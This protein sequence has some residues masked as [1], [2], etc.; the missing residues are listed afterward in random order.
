[1]KI[2][3]FQNLLIRQLR[4]RS[5]D[6]T[7][8][9]T[10]PL[11]SEYALSFL[12]KYPRNFNCRLP[13]LSFSFNFPCDLLVA[14]VF[15]PIVFPTSLWITPIPLTSSIVL[16]FEEI[17]RTGRGMLYSISILYSFFL[18]MFTCFLYL[19]LFLGMICFSVPTHLRISVPHF[20]SFVKP[21]P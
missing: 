12:I 21:I 11:G 6:R 14:H 9:D 7:L 4:R 15:P 2:T 8:N 3:K 16:I 19:C 17:F 1:M 13:S 10:S 18:T 5:R 20:Q